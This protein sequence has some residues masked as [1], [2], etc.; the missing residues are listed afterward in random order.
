M[1]VSNISTGY[2]DM[3]ALGKRSEAQE[4]AAAH[5]PPSALRNSPAGEIASVLGEI[6]SHY[7]VTDISPTEFSEMIQELYESGAITDAELQELAA[8]RHDLDAADVDP[9]ESIDLLEFY[10]EKIEDIQRRLSDADQA[11]PGRQELAPV[12]RRLDWVEKLA[13]I[14]SAPDAVGLDTIV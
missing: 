10:A 5:R 11:S 3:A 4:A 7:D 6:L 9:D 8:I 12:L 14:Q 2:S 13:L 1:Q